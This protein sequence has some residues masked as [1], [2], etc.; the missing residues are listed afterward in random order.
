MAFL[1]HCK[2]HFF[3]CCEAR[4][5]VPGFQGFLRA[6]GFKNGLRLD[7]PHLFFGSCPVF[8]L[9][10]KWKRIRESGGEALTP[11]FGWS[12][13]WSLP[14]EQTGERRRFYCSATCAIPQLLN[15]PGNLK[16]SICHFNHPEVISFIFAYFFP[17][18]FHIW[19]L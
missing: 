12:P 14:L 19:A 1:L 15:M 5:N 16:V 11:V 3:F 4:E 8:G 10:L 6:E 17:C 2:F 13:G 7:L 9:A 18:L